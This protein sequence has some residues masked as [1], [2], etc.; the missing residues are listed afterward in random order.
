[1]LSTLRLV[2]LVASFV[3]VQAHATSILVIEA[4]RTA[5]SPSIVTFA[6]RT[7]PNDMAAINSPS[8]RTFKSA[9]GVEDTTAAVKDGA[10]HIAPLPLRG[11]ID[12]PANRAGLKR[13][14]DAGEANSPS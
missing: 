14:A 8:I 13:E 1:M 3:V 2:S 6:L 4:D 12:L 5:S 9:V 10:R 11:Q 7:E